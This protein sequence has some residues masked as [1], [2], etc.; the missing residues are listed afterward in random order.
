M[1]GHKMVGGLEYAFI[2]FS[3]ISYSKHFTSFHPLT[4]FNIH[5]LMVGAAIKALT[6]SSETM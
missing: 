5:T 1:D 2:L 6:C 3:S 4:H